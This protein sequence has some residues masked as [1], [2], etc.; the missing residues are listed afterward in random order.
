[1]RADLLGDNAALLKDNLPCSVLFFNDRAVDVTLPN[2]V[3]LEVVSTEQGVR[4]ATSGNVLK[5]PKVETG[6]EIGVPLFINQG[7]VI[8]IDTRTKEYVERVKR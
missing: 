5:P 7:D 6:A 2:F 1:M 4:G 3:V 8:R